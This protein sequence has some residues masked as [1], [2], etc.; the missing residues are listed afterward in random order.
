MFCTWLFLI[1]VCSELYLVHAHGPGHHVH[2]RSRDLVVYDHVY[3]CL[4]EYSDKVFASFN[5]REQVY[6]ECNLYE[7]FKSCLSKHKDDTF[8]PMFVVKLEK[9]M[10]FCHCLTDL[11]EFLKMPRIKLETVSRIVCRMY[12]EQSKCLQGYFYSNPF[13]KNLLTDLQLKLKSEYCAL[14]F[15]ESWQT[16]SST[17]WSTPHTTG[18]TVNLLM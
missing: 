2:G 14:A 12:E 15:K 4:M 6:N 17:F 3:R 7:Q 18:D 11:A 10:N 5:S 9:S 13:I 1:S 16:S 8:I